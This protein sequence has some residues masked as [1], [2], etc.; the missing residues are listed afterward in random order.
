MNITKLTLSELSQKFQDGELT[1]R[2]ITE[3]FIKNIEDRDKDINAFVTTTFDL[4][5][6][7]AD[8]ADSRYQNDT[9]KSPLDGMPIDLKD[10]ISTKEVRTTASSKI[11]MI[12][13]HHL[14]QL[15]GKN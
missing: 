8:A 3:A 13:N 11:L 4:A 6:E 10:V 5:R 2:E 15:Y 9:L 12:I 1:S 7:M 14:M